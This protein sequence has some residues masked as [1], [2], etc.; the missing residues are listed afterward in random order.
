MATL[1]EKVTAY[2]EE[3]EK[4]GPIHEELQKL[5]EQRAQQVE[6]IRRLTAHNQNVTGQLQAVFDNSDKVDPEIARKASEYDTLL[7]RY[8]ELQTTRINLENELQ[9][10]R[11]ERATILRENALLRESSNPESYSKLKQ[12]HESLKAHCE[13]IESV[14]AAQEDTSREMQTKLD[15]ATNPQV[16]EGIQKRL[17]KY[18][19]ERVLHRNKIKRIEQQLA[20]AEA[21][22]EAAQDTLKETNEQSERVAAQFQQTIN[23]KEFELSHTEKKMYRYRDERNSVRLKCKDLEKQLAHW[24]ELFHKSSGLMSTS[25]HDDQSIEYDTAYSSPHPASDHT[26]SPTSD[27]HPQAYTDDQIQLPYQHEDKEVAELESN[28]NSLSMEPSKMNRKRTAT[29]NR[30]KQFTEFDMVDVQ[31]KE[32]TKVMRIG[33]PRGALSAK[34]RPKVV[35]KRGEEYEQGTLMFVGEVGGR[36]LAGIQMDCRVSSKEWLYRSHMCIWYSDYCGH[37]WPSIM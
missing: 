36:E 3:F 17:E 30:T 16:L 28:F 5:R 20:E 14:L 27:Y 18:K 2:Q 29:L 25:D 1:W 4:I 37:L 12:E 9:P 22:K 7:D 10:L 31:T 13:Q 15:E 8:H 32:G 21:E 26:S 23:H 11:Q 33:R 24:K 34:N 6:E 35:V 19:A